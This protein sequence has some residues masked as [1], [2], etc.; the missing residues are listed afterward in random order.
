M[1]K[2][3]NESLSKVIKHLESYGFVKCYGNNGIIDSLKF[4]PTGQLLCET[5]KKEWIHWNVIR[6]EHNVFTFHSSREDEFV[7]GNLLY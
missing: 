3:A 1:I 6:R 2:I 7:S 5:I 4:G